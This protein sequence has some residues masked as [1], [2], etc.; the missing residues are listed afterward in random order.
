MIRYRGVA[1]YPEFWPE[2]R[3]DEDIR[4]MREAHI[5]LVRIGEFAWTPMEPAEGRFDLGWLHRIIEKMGAAGIEVMLCTPTATPPAWLTKACPDTLLVTREGKRAVHGGRRHYCP[6]S[7]TYRR[8]VER[9]TERLASE[10]SRYPNVTSWQIDNEL[11]P[12]SGE[13]YC[14]S[15]AS[16]FRGWLER[17]Y[18]NLERLNAAWQTRFWSVVYT[19]WAEIDIRHC[20]AGYPSIDLDVRRFHSDSWVDFAAHQAGILRRLHPGSTVTTNMMGPVFRWID[21]HDLAKVVDVACDDLYFDMATMSGDALAADVFRCLKPGKRF[22]VTETGSASLVTGKP[23]HADQLRAWAF[24]SAARG[25]DAHVIFR[26]RTCLAGQEQD[27]QGI[28]ETSGKPRRRYAAVKRLF[29]ELEDLVPALGSLPLPKAD[30][31]LVHTYDSHWAWQSTRIGGQ[32]KELEHLYAVHELLFDRNVLVDPVPT[33]RDLSPYK[34]VVLPSV[35]IVRPETVAALQAFVRA[36]GVVLA[37]PQ[38]ASRDVNN[39]YVPRCAPDGLTDLFGL[40]VEGKAFLDDASEPDRAIWFP[41]GNMVLE[42][43]HAR[44]EDGTACEARAYVEDLELVGAK[45]L[46]RFTD[47]LYEGCPAAT[48]NEA[49]K[50]AA[51]YAA[52]YLDADGLGSLLDLALQRAGI[53]PGP[54]TPKWV[55]VV[56]RGDVTFAVNHS[57]EPCTVEIPGREAVVGEWKKGKARLGAY[58]VCAV[59]G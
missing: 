24:S 40:R 49:G 3:W 57:R 14:E 16:G 58:G 6:T 25:S 45:A 11:G 32:V 26:W 55:E 5:N 27:L 50:G 56:R 12:E 48:V 35:C 37:T 1:Y 59:R 7:A 36:G 51:F 15:C 18:G 8:H 31:A 21:Y 41:K 23:P 46:A 54:R 42:T 53:A 47:N 2:D 29:E 38:L 10:F 43:A 19:D 13:C 28:I 22:W 34:L 33:D 52:S 30:V 39:N 17:R 4:L 20:E 9:I 44:F